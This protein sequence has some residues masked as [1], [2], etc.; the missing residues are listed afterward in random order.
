LKTK[1]MR[2]KG[3]I[4]LVIDHGSDKTKEKMVLAAMTLFEGTDCWDVIDI[5]LEDHPAA[6][7]WS[8]SGSG[9]DFYST[10]RPETPEEAEYL[11]SVLREYE[12]LKDGSFR[13][14]TFRG[15]VRGECEI[16]GYAPAWYQEFKR[17]VFHSFRNGLTHLK[18]IQAFWESYNGSI[19]DSKIKNPYRQATETDI[20]FGISSKFGRLAGLGL[21]IDI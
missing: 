20:Q 8:G 3:R 18:E 6:N 12:E 2:E 9:D 5:R 4:S 10:Y 7:P 17:P 11:R 15:I 19:R 21:S 13:W 1:L 16:N 14:C